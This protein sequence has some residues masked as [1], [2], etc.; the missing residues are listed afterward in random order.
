MEQESEM[1]FYCRLLHNGIQKEAFYRQGESEKSVRDGLELFD[2]G[3][4]AWIISQ[5]SSVPPIEADRL[6]TRTVVS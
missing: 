5:A 4:G 1:L 3:S 6:T 2:Y